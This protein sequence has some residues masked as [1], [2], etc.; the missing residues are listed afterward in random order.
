MILS[1]SM[2][3]P[4]FLLVFW[5]KIGKIDK[6]HIQGSSA[7]N[8]VTFLNNGEVFSDLDIKGWLVGK[9]TFKDRFFFYFEKGRGFESPAIFVCVCV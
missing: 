7:K 3:L 9:V 6:F 1:T 5:G 2:H 4:I 8:P